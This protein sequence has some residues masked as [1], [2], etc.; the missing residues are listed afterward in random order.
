MKSFCRA[1]TTTRTSAQYAV[2]A[3]TV[4]LISQRFDELV[5]LLSKVHVE[6]GHYETIDSYFGIDS[7]TDAPAI[8]G[9][10]VTNTWASKQAWSSDTTASSAEAPFAPEAN[11]DRLVVTEG[12]TAENDSDVDSKTRRSTP[13]NGFMYE[14]ASSSPVRHNTVFAR[15]GDGLSVYD[16]ETLEPALNSAYDTIYEASKSHYDTIQETQSSQSYDFLQ[17]QPVAD[18]NPHLYGIDSSP[19]A[20]GSSHV[21]RLESLPENEIQ[22]HP[23]SVTRDIATALLLRAWPQCRSQNRIPFLIRERPD[24][25]SFVLSVLLAEDRFEHYLIEETSPA[26]FTLNGKPVPQTTLAALVNRITSSLDRPVHIVKPVSNSDSTVI[27]WGQK[28][29]MPTQSPWD[30]SQYDMGRAEPLLTSSA[31]VGLVQQIGNHPS[32]FGSMIM[33]S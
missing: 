18:R 25:K 11:Y 29:V 12:R 16:Y 28:R 22:P 23:P 7:S 4:S 8:A 31:H 21:K 15:P 13:A 19:A 14:L 27:D 20:R 17:D 9:A 26:H 1:G 5:D 6:D 10:S 30:E 2:C 32:T 24:V 33:A 3:V